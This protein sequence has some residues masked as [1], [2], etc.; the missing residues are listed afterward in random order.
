M[1]ENI[2]W[3]LNPKRLKAWQRHYEFREQ[4]RRDDED[5]RAWLHG[6]Y[7]LSAIG[8]A[9][10]GKKCPY[11]TEPFSVAQRREE[12]EE[13]SQYAADRFKA[14]AMAFNE[15]FRKRQEAKAQENP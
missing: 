14:F 12:Q 7:I 13:A 15:G 4:L 6:Q 11:P 1:P 10:D 9:V 8:A 3:S 5:Y 2:F